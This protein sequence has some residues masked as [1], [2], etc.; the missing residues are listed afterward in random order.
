MLRTRPG[1]THK[2]FSD[3]VGLDEI[4]RPHCADALVARF[5]E[6]PDIPTR[7]LRAALRLGLL[8]DHLLA[9]SRTALR[10]GIRAIA[11]KA[12]LDGEVT[13][14]ARFARY[15]R[16]WTD[17]RY[18][19]IPR[20]PVLGRRAVTQPRRAAAKRNP[21]HTIL[22]GLCLRLTRPTVSQTPDAV[23]RTHLMKLRYDASASISF[24][25]KLRATRGIGYAP[26]A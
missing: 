16:Q 1:M 2:E 8:D 6:T 26:T 9:L 25:D 11:L 14:L 12:L 18:G 4:P 15:E 10:P 5:L 17:K 20:V 23:T 13:W 3:P 21:A 7:I 24:G 22:G 19:Q